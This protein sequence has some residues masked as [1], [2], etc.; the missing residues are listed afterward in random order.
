MK[1]D[2]SL[3]D[4]EKVTAWLESLPAET[5]VGKSQIACECPLAK[6]FRS[7]GIIAEIGSKGTASLCT[8]DD[9]YKLIA[10][11]RDIIMPEWARWFVAEVDILGRFKPC[12]R[13]NM[14]DVI[15]GIKCEKNKSKKRSE[16]K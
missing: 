4:Q 1:L 10:Q 2:A 5:I 12:V 6:Y 11:E 16:K 7:L 9:Q 15:K 13:E 14:L 3:F 8:V